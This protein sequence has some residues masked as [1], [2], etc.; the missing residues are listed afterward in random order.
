MKIICVSGTPGTGKSTLAKAL[1]KELGYPVLDVKKFIKEKNLSSGYDE[2]KRCEIIDVKL[3][4]KEL[5]KEI[6]KV[7][8]EKPKGIVIDSHLSHYLPKKYVDLVV[9]TKCK[10]K[11][12][13]KRLEKRRYSKSKVRDNLDS[14]IFDICFNEAKEAGHD[15][16]V[17]NMSEIN[18]KQRNDEIKQLK[19]SISEQNQ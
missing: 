18:K 8:K 3:L 2:E 9:V 12:L 10:L 1:M 16:F 14:E 17:V 5:I 19:I 11:E 4:N 7:K 6:N 15:V 13:E